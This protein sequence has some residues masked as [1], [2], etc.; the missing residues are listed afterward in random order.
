MAEGQN[1]GLTVT[2]LPPDGASPA[3]AADR[4][5]RRLS[6]A[7]GGVP[8]S[9]F[10]EASRIAEAVMA[11]A[12]AP[13][14][15]CYLLGGLRCRIRY[16]DRGVES[17]V[18]RALAHVEVAATAEPDLDIGVWDEARALHLLP[19]PHPHML[20]DYKN[21][22]LQLCSDSRYLALDER[23]LGTRSYI[24]RLSG[25]AWYCFR[26]VAALPYYEKTA[27]LRSVLNTLLAERRRHLVHAAAVGTPESGLLLTGASGAG[28]SSTALAC[29]SGSLRYL[30]DDFCGIQA[31]HQPRIFSVYSSAKLRADNLDRFPEVRLRTD[32][33]ERLDQEK[34]A[35]FI[36]E[37]WAD[38]MLIDCPVKAILIPVVTGN[39]RTTIQATPGKDAWRAM[40]SW[41]LRQLAGWGRESITLITE[42]CAPLPAFRLLLGTE[43]REI[44]ATLED[45]AAGL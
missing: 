20:V 31:G 3:A 21:H 12:P 26:D 11:D 24:D 36:A 2:A 15:R 40:L 33:Y 27:P 1:S 17:A 10:L 8:H 14:Q 23:W 7:F 22:C 39:A 35:T 19:E 42:F 18:H 29:L 4:R 44:G 43:P 41:T 25:K 13:S 30:A 5:P 38:R 34:A 6:Q 37:H 45:F 28:K 32:G 16:A 9:Y